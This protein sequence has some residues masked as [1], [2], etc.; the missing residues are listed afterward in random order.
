MVQISF[1]GLTFGKK[2]V[3]KSIQQ[4]SIAITDSINT[5][6]INSVDLNNSILYV[7]G[8]FATWD[9]GATTAEFSIRC[10]FTNATTVTAK[11]FKSTGAVDTTVRFTVV[12]YFPGYIKSRQFIN[13]G[14]TTGTIHTHTI[15][16]VNTAKSFIVCT[17]TEVETDVYTNSSDAERAWANALITNSTTVTVY[18]NLSAAGLQTT[19]SFQVIEFY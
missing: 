4:G 3:I 8:Q 7:N 15:S 9:A 6:N 19:F 2:A 17:G 18:C 16:S 5:A 12:E 13:K 14:L 1:G 10:F 11:R